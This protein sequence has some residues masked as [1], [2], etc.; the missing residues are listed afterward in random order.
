MGPDD[1]VHDKMGLYIYFDPRKDH[2]G[3]QEDINILD[4]APT[5]LKAIGLKIPNDMEGK[6]LNI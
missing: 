4:I 2:V 3:R 5:L 6:S 1:A